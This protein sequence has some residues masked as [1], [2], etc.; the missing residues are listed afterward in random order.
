MIPRYTPPA[1]AALWSSETRYAVWL[2]VELAACE[3]MEAEGLVPVGV[4]RALRDKNLKLDPARIEEIERTVKHDVIAFL[5]HVEELAGPDARWLHRGMTSSDVLDTSLAVLL[6]R[7]ADLLLERLDG[8]IVALSRRADEHRRTPMIGRSH[9]IHAEPI[10]FGLAL[11]GHLAEMK[12][13]RTRLREARSEIAVGKISGAVGTYAHLSPKIEA[14]AL[15]AL[16]LRPETVATQ[17]VPRDRHAAFFNALALVAAGI[18]RLATNVRH[19]QRTEVAEAEERFTQGQKG[20]SAMPHKRNPILSENLCGLARIVRA[21]AMPALED[22][23]LWH[24]RDI[25]HSS[26]ERMIAPDA[27][28]T[29]GFMLERTS[30]LVDGLVVREENL[31][32]NLELSGGLFFSE[33][34]L[35]ALVSYGLPRQEAYVLVQ[36]NAMKALA[37]EGTFRDLLGADPDVSA[38]LSAAELDRCFDL[39]HA[40]SHVSGI[41]DRAIAAP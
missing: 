32:K 21:A 22:V 39:E 14:Q 26:V 13:G 7:A 17:V 28:T 24:E 3:A 37:G 16:G 23:V 33:A 35:L 1:F 8:L 2:D 41:V 34:V 40:L 25:S 12:R 29:L 5:T 6:V 19:W 9:G 27:T 10:T 20:S 15:A 36:R 38:R 11:A 30:S 18:E 4:A 31:R